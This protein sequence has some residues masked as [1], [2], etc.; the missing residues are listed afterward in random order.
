MSER[1]DILI[2][3]Y[4]RFVVV[5][6]V[7]FVPFLYLISYMS[8]TENISFNVFLN[9]LFEWAVLLPFGFE[10]NI[11]E[12]FVPLIRFFFWS[13][14]LITATRWVITGRHFYQ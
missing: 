10:Q 4:L 11:P 12:A 9:S 6:W 14:W 7:G 13:F 1:L 2:K 5:I 8:G 3:N